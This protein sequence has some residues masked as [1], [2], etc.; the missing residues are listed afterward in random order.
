MMYN[1]YFNPR[2]AGTARK[3]GPFDCRWRAEEAAINLAARDD[4]DWINI[5]AEDEDEG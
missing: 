2:V 5:V 1:I 4:V 3:V